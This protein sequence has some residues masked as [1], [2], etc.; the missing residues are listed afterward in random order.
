MGFSIVKRDIHNLLQNKSHIIPLCRFLFLQISSVLHF[1]AIS[2][3]FLTTILSRGLG[4]GVPA[5]TEPLEYFGTS[6]YVLETQSDDID[7]C[8][9]SKL[10]Y[11]PCFQCSSIV[12]F[13]YLCVPVSVLS[14]NM[15]LV[16]E[17]LLICFSII[18]LF[19]DIFVDPA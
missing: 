11:E 18:S 9:H 5:S 16:L 19:I 4:N 10:C 17:L 12:H 14:P 7:F 13:N 1:T 8:G 3:T 6:M 2:A 15:L